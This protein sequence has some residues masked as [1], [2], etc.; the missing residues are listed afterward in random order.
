[1]SVPPLDWDRKTFRRIRGE[2]I[3]EEK[4]EKEKEKEKEETET[5]TEIEIKIEGDKK[6]ELR[7]EESQ[8]D[9]E[10]IKN[11]DATFGTCQG[12]DERILDRMNHIVI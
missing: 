6:Y 8:E 7:R 5:E 10:Q 12:M 1:M 11:A 3:S 4:E 2:E 9:A